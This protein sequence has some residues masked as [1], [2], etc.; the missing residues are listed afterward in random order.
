MTRQTF[1][2]VVIAIVIAAVL[3]GASLIVARGSAGSAIDTTSGFVH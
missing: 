1:V 3:G 2:R